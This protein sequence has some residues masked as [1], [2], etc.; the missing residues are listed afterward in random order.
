[1][2]T[3]EQ[4]LHHRPNGRGAKHQSLF[5][6]TGIEHAIGENMAALKIGPQL[7]FSDHEEGDL[8][9]AWHRLHGAHPESGIPRLDL[10]PASDQS[11]RILAD[12]IDNLVV[13]LARQQPQRQSDNAAGMRQHALDGEMGLS[14]VGRTQHRRDTGAAG[15]RC[16][17]RLLGKTDGHYASGLARE[18]WSGPL[19]RP[20]CITMRRQ[21]C[22]WLSF[23]TSLEQK[24][25][26]SLTPEL[27][28]FV[29]GDIW[30]AVAAQ[31]QDGVAEP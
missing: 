5:T 25:P 31:P 16:T 19:S 29:H 3:G 10:F 14:G 17:G 23:R 24:A 7:D 12:T 26:E 13:D 6:S 21:A 30:R 22:A 28:D 27:Y 8:E 18:P 4:L 11:N 2:R 9:I 15:S 20:P 1:M